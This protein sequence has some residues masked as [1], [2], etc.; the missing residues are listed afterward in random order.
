VLRNGIGE[1]LVRAT[2][3]CTLLRSRRAVRRCADTGRLVRLLSEELDRL[4]EAYCSGG[5]V[6]T[7][8]Y[9]GAVRAAVEGID[10]GRDS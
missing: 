2:A 8:Q 6:G 3:L 10:V 9:D 5:Q 1:R 7:K 4:K